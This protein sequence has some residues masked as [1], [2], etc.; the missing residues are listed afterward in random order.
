MSLDPIIGRPLQSMLKP[1]RVR[2]ALVRQVGGPF[3]VEDLSL[4]PPGRGE[5]M[6]RVH[7]TG[8]CHT[9]LVCRDGFPVPLPIVLGH[10]GAGTV[11]ALGDGVESLQVGDPVV[12]SFGSCGQCPNCARHQPAYCHSMVPI[13]FGGQRWPDGGTALL[14][15]DRPVH[16][17]FFDQS[18]FATYAIGRARSA[19]KVESDLPLHLLGPLACSMQTGA[20]AVMRSL[21]LQRDES[22]AVF[23]GGAVG[24]SAVMMAR[25]LEASHI[26]VVEPV[27]AR[28]ALALELG[29]TAAIDPHGSGDVVTALREATGGGVY[30]ALDTTGLPQVIEQAFQ[31]L[32]PN[33]LLGLLGV[34]APDAQLPVR[35]MDLVLRGAGVKAIL[36]GDSDP[37]TFIPLLLALY[38]AGRFPFDRLVRTYPFEAI[39]E[40]AGAAASGEVIKPVLLFG[41]GG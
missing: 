39:N 33:G 17:H 2:A 24:L 8:I 30:R 4:S 36:E 26:V 31:A 1:Q 10:E 11:V 35:I 28:R 38:R 3:I 34:S 13:N 40:A 21:R 41:A 27:A 32:A 9:D 29:A 22:F 18:S 14:Q 37:Q 6:V 16:G 23:G 19:V 5:I 7:G 15:G 25:H 12:M 20:G